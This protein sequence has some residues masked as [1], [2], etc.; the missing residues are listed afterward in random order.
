MKI[1][2]NSDLT[3]RVISALDHAGAHHFLRIPEAVGTMF[4]PEGVIPRTISWEA[5]LFVVPGL[6]VEQIDRLVHELRD[7]VGECS[8]ENCLR[9][10]V[11]RVE[12]LL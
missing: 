11:S 7:V 3:D 5:T 2:C 12:R 1:L 10:L 6:T 8:A 9:I 4:E